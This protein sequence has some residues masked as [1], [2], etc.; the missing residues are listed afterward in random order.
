MPKIRSFVW[1]KGAG[2]TSALPVS[3]VQSWLPPF[4]SFALIWFFVVLLA[5]PIAAQADC[6]NGVPESGSAAS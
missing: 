4:S 2:A 3:L 5:T 6:G 1:L